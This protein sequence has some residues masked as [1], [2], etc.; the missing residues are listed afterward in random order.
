MSKYSNQIKQHVYYNLG[1]IENQLDDVTT[2]NVKSEVQSALEWND[3][4]A[5]EFCYDSELLEII[6]DSDLE[7][8]DEVY[9]DGVDSAMEAVRR[10]A[11]AIVDATY[12]AYLNTALGELKEALDDGVNILEDMGLEVERI[13]GGNAGYDTSVHS[14]KHDVGDGGNMFLWRKHDMAQI[15][16]NGMSFKL[17]VVTSE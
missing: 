8:P 6:V 4:Y 7:D 3:C 9:F 1:A 11:R 2:S 14:E 13:S 10:E 12:Y 16:I 15:N 5:P 17:S